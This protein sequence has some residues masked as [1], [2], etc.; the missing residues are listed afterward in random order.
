M[1]DKAVEYLLTSWEQ[2]KCICEILS[3]WPPEINYFLQ[4]TRKTG[5]STEEDLYSKLHKWDH[6]EC[7]RRRGVEANSD[8]DVAGDVG[9]DGDG[10]MDATASTVSAG[11]KRAGC[12]MSET[13]ECEPVSKQA[14]AA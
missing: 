9:G 14:K 12:S 6:A 10:M 3:E 2:G 4:S 7:L 13:M 5:I 8:V 1:H 11:S